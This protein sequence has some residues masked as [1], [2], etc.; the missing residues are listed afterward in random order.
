LIAGSTLLIR[1]YFLSGFYSTGMR[2]P[3][4]GFIPSGALLKAVLI[5]GTSSLKYIQHDD[6]SSGSSKGGTESTSLGDNNQGYGRVQLNKVL[7]FGV[8]STL[9]GITLFVKGAAYPTGSGSD[10][11]A[12]ITSLTSP[13]TYS[14]RTQ[15]RDDLDPIRITLVYTVWLSFSPLSF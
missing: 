13:H 1:E 15:D 11:Y 12:E 7:S 6:S 2:N 10:H 5:H 3:I 14:F 4:H 9:D 8:N